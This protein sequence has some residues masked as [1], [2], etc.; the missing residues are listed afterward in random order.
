[1]STLTLPIKQPFDPSAIEVEVKNV[2]LGV[3]IDLLKNEAIDLTPAFQ[4]K[5]DLWN[6]EKKS[7]LVESI[8]LGLPLPSFYFSI[9]K[10]SKRWV[11]I[12]GLQR[13]CTLKKF[14][15]DQALELKG[16]DFLG[17]QYGKKT[18]NDF[19]YFEKLSFS[20]LS[21]TVNILKGKT[22]PDVKYL[23]FQRIN[24][25]GTPLT[26]QEIRNALNQGVA[27]RLLEDMADIPLFRQ[28]TKGVSTQRMADKEFVLRFLAFYLIGYESYEGDMDAFLNVAMHAL[29]QLSQDDLDGAKVAFCRGLFV[30][31]E[32]L[33]DDAFRKPI[34][35]SGR[36]N[37]VSKALFDALAV[38]VSKLTQAEQ[39]DLILKKTLFS[40]FYIELFQDKRLQKTLSEGTGKSKS[41]GYRFQKI[42]EVIRKTLG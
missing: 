20:M 26:P 8:L 33:G 29:N 7:R 35:D 11:V 16:L 10:D 9:E 28:M 13:L 36:R 17:K 27:T 42:E 19:E 34:S 21:V 2:T 15:I 25:A 5:Q 14:A 4:R 41:V 39:D 30:C 37:P 40:T 31:R 38:S 3:L 22:P 18:Y 1:M 12:D 23:I 32:L 24:S 6:D